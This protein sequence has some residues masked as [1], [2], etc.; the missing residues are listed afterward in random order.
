MAERVPCQVCGRRLVPLKSGLHRYH[1]PPRSA[2]HTRCQGVG[3]RAERWPVGQQLRH[4]AGSLW[5]VVEDRGASTRWGDYLLRCLWVPKGVR[6]R[7]VGTEMVT[8]GEYMHRHG[9][10]PVEPRAE[11]GRS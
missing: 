3:Y 1:A 11:R 9:W 7:L 4:H 10:N 2:P 8:H 5:E 6:E